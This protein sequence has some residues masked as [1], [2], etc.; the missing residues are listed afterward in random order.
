MPERALFEQ[1]ISARWHLHCIEAGILL[2]RE[3][4]SEGISLATRDA[5]KVA[6]MLHETLSLL[7]YYREVLSSNGPDAP[8]QV[9]FQLQLEP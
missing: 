9:Y 3:V 1:V 5:A 6:A 4:G 7:S 8:D 2:S